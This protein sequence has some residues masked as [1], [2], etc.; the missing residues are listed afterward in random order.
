MWSTDAERLALLELVVSGRLRRRAGHAAAFDHLAALSWTRRASR[1]DEILLAEDRRVELIALLDRVWPAWT[2]ARAEL[3]THALPPTL[4]GW[5]QLQDLR[6]AARMP[7]L[8]ER[9]NRHTAATLAAPHSK[10]SLTRTRRAALGETQ[11]THDGLIRI[12]PPVGLRARTAD[13]ALDLGEIGR[14]LGEV[15]LPER[16][17]LDGLTLEGPLRATVTIENLGAWRDLPAVPGCLLVHVPGWNTTTTLSHLL[18]RVA[19]APLVHFG[20]LDPA[21]ARIIR[22]LRESRA[23]VCWLVPSFWGEY[24]DAYGLPCEWPPEL[25]SPELPPL[26]Q[27]LARRGLW[28]EQ[29]RLVIDPRIGGAIEAVLG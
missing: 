6:R 28:L 14:V 11:A 25:V 22:H 18:A 5:S 10:S 19:H 16:A 20:D 15:A 26:V 7:E 2:E 13:G 9:I 4:D 8:P 1:K 12:R 27:D 29:E 17:F 21:G 23:D 3:E 24:V